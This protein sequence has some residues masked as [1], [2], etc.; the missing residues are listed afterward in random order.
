MMHNRYSIDIC[1]ETREIP[2][3]EVVIYV[4]SAGS[5]KYRFS[6]KKKIVTCKFTPRQRAFLKIKCNDDFPSTT[7]YGRFNYQSFVMNNH[8]KNTK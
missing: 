7:L 1:R 5:T 3:P 8:H 2:V 6:G 4:C